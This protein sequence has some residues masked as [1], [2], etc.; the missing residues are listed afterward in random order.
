LDEAAQRVA[1]LTA[2]VAALLDDGGIGEKIREGL[3]I[4]IIGAPNAGKSSLLNWLARRDAAIVSAQAGTTRDLI[5]VPMEIGGYAVTVV[6]TAGIR[7]SAGDIEAEGIRRALHRAEHADIT[8]R[9]YDITTIAEYSME[10]NAE[11]HKNSI[12]IAT[13]SDLAPLPALPFSVLAIS[14]KTG[15]GM[16][17]LI[18][19]LK[20]KIAQQM[21]SAAA[22]LIT[23]A[24]HRAALMEALACLQ[25]FKA[26]D[27]L[28]LV[29]E[30]L[31]LAAQAIG[32]ITG[33][34]WVDDVLDLVFSR[35]CIGK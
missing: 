33:K 15:E 1:S 9:V 18:V 29:C 30:E 5:A 2:E 35:F 3:D 11:A 13:K 22:P 16:E 28:E 10:F 4:V 21:E 24:R 20:E 23:R 8:L 34:I 6:D 7:E 31:R 26:H 14:T 19:A 27:P 12:T 25:R 17:A 32:K